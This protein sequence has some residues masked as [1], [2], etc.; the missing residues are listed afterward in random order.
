MSTHLLR[1]YCGPQVSP[2]IVP[3]NHTQALPVSSRIRGS[4]LDSITAYSMTETLQQ[5]VS[6]A[7]HFQ[8]QF[9][10]DVQTSAARFDSIT[11][12]PMAGWGT[13]QARAAGSA[14]DRK[15]R[16]PATAWA[17]M[18]TAVHTQ[19]CSSTPQSAAHLMSCM[20]A[21]MAADGATSALV[22]TTATGTSRARATARCSRVTLDS[23][24]M[25]H[26]H[27][28]TWSGSCRAEEEGSSQRYC[29]CLRV[30]ARCSHVALDWLVRG[31]S[32]Q[33]G[34]R[35]AVHAVH[36]PLAGL[37]LRLA[38]VRHITNACQA[39]ARQLQGTVNT[40]PPR[41]C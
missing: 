37:L 31:Q 11:A 19:Q 3:M 34:S 26:T 20:A 40:V 16:L 17:A 24:V 38:Q 29:W 39:V 15:R 28:S 32:T 6:Q 1:C 2:W 5:Q 18:Q 35:H 10:S 9:V 23:P 25:G 41:V 22:N 14:Q 4:R 36:A 12:C 7:D 21:A 27:S 33:S 13:D 8:M 30:Q